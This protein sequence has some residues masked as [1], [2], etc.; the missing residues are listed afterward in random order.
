VKKLSSDL[1]HLHVPNPI[2]ELSC[3]L[4]RGDRPLI[5]HCHSDVVRQKVLNPVYGPLLHRL[6]KEAVLIIT[7]TPNHIS[8]SAFISA[9]QDKCRIVPYGIDLKRFESVDGA[10]VTALRSGTP[11]I[12]FVGRLVYYKGVDVLIHAVRDTGCNLWIVGG[13]PL[14]PE[15]RQLTQRLG[16]ERRVKFLG[17]LPGDELMH[18]FHACDFFAL[19][20]VAFSEMFGIVQLEAMACGKA[21]IASNLPTGVSWVNQHGVTGLLPAPG[22]VPEWAAA[23]DRL[24]KDATL[25]QQMGS[26]ARRRV[27]QCFSAKAYGEGILNVYREALRTRNQ[28]AVAG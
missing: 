27:E 8:A 10:R 13:G 19:P 14:E 26:A 3:L 5:V 6:Y 4:S 2:G 7:P 20:S 18:Y 24:E 23:I 17:R 16:L 12:L 9:Y 28:Q 21:V 22:N 11:T 25:R 1:I 15:L